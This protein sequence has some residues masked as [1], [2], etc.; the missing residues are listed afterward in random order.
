MT[1][2]LQKTYGIGAQTFLD[3]E[4]IRQPLVMNARSGHGTLYIE[5]VVDYIHDDL[6]GRCYDPGTSRTARYQKIVA[7]FPDDSR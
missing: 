3:P 1:L 5:I 7:I 2:L 6:Q 4:L